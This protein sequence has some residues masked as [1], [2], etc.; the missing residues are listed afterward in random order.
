MIATIE[1]KKLKIKFVAKN[2]TD[3]ALKQ[4]EVTLEVSNTMSFQEMHQQVV[5]NY[6]SDEIMPNEYDIKIEDEVVNVQG[7][8]FDYEEELLLGDVGVIELCGMLYL[9]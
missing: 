2:F 9:L 1:P 5:T 7:F 4:N 6:F 8:I 3:F